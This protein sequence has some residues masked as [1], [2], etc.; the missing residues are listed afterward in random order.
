MGNTTFETDAQKGSL[1]EM[2]NCMDSNGESTAVALK[3]L[4]T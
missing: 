1:T 3:R 2:V 4:E